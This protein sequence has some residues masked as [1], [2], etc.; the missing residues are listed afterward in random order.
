[1]GKIFTELQPHAFPSNMQQ[2]KQQ[3]QNQSIYFQFCLVL[4]RFCL[5]SLVLIYDWLFCFVVLL[6]LLI[7]FKLVS[8]FKSFRSEVG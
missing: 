3:N 5:F 4:D 8:H 6:L 1:M 7:F 2:E